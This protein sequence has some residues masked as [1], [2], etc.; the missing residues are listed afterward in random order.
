MYVVI[1]Y[2]VDESRVGRM[3]RFL[4]RYVVWVQN[5]VFE[6]EISEALLA[7]MEGRMRKLLKINDSVLIYAAKTKSML[8]RK[9]IGTERG[10]IDN[11]I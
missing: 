4:K 7:D 9:V 5:S 11:V 2:D 6:G 10:I 3:N 8:D 1:V